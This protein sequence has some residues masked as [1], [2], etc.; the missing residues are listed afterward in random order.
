MT[1]NITLIIVENEVNRGLFREHFNHAP[2]DYR[3]LVNPMMLN[4]YRI[5]RLTRERGQI[6]GKVFHRS[7]MMQNI[8]LEQIW[9]EDGATPWYI[10]HKND[11]RYYDQLKSMATNPMWHNESEKIE[12]LRRLRHQLA[13]EMLKELVSC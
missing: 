9:V 5:L 13:A 6:S 12:V 7:E 11:W 2:Q 3:V 1:R 4:S 8:R 10:W